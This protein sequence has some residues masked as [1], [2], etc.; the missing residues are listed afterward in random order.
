MD[1]GSTIIGIV[2]V[3]ICILPFIMMNNGR[4]KREKVLLQSLS[5]IAARYNCQISRYDVFSNFAIGI[6]EAKNVVFFFKQND[7]N[8]MTQFVDLS[9]IQSCKVINTSRTLK[10]RDGNQKIT[11]RLELNFIPAVKNLPEVKMEFFN[12]EVSLH[13][14]GEIQTIEKWCELINSRLKYKN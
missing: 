12:A 13:L 5:E 14:N 6:D 3:I 9:K 2:A 8:K 4:K 1:L 10:S 11:D 7:D